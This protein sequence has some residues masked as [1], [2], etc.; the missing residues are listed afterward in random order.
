MASYIQSLKNQD[1]DN[2]YPVTVTDAVYLQETQSDGTVQQQTLTQKLAAMTQ[3]FTDG[4]NTIVAKITSLGVTPKET[5]PDGVADAV[6]DLYNSV[7]VSQ[8]VNENTVTATAKNGNTSTATVPLGNGDGNLT[9]DLS[10]EGAENTDY[11]MGAGYY[12]AGTISVN[13]L[14]S[15][16]AGYQY[17][18]ERLHID[19]GKGNMC[20]RHVYRD[21]YDAHAYVNIDPVKLVNGKL[22]VTLKMYL[23]LYDGSGN[24]SGGWGT[25]STASFTL[26]N[27]TPN[28]G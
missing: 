12:H 7:T 23:S 28:I 6:D 4:V 5:T 26:D 3:S 25:A 21:D 2:V 19:K 20:E 16:K 13:G 11:D 22:T 1:G 14:E 8:T 24:G 15:Y 17:A 10:A 18:V 27:T 9:L